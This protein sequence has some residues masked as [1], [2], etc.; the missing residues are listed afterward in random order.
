[1]PAAL[2]DIEAAFSPLLAARHVALAISGGS[3]SIAMM[4]L[5]RRWAV[6]RHPALRLTVLTV[7]HRLR[8]ASAAEAEQVAK[9]AGV[10][11]LPHTKLTWRHTEKP[12]TGIQAKARVARYDLMSAWCA[13]HGADFLLTAHTLD[14]Q[15][16]TVLMRLARTRSPESLAGIR[17]LLDWRGVRIMRPLLGL[18]RQALRDYL[19]FEGQD[20]LEDP[21]NEDPRF[22]RV[23]VRRALGS[24]SSVQPLAE[25]LA[26]LAQASASAAGL[27]SAAVD[28]WLS[29][30]LTEDEAGFCLVPRAPFGLLA[31]QLQA[32]VL[33]RLVHHY[34]GQQ[35]LPEAAEVQRLAVWAAGQ[36][37][38]PRRTLAGALVGRRKATL[39]ITREAG[40]IP[41]QA[42]IVPGT[43]KLLWDNRF[44]IEAAP[45]SRVEAAGTRPLCLAGTVPAHVRRAYPW[46]QVPDRSAAA[47]VRFQPLL[48]RQ[49]IC[50]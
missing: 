22:E 50:T 29:R 17:P 16:E 3:D 34:G 49:Q 28:A 43:G 24:A 21:S 9:W 25:Q 37:G 31:E 15:A 4:H 10:L 18:R 38:P 45:G 13:S 26:A 7:D 27:Q 11:G 19:V 14:D 30:W 46:V 12:V 1:M 48:A 47:E 44:M 41:D 5:A 8:A 33:A 32:Q 20:W 35:P 2:P 36:D 42:A 6:E 39:W 23:R 40:R